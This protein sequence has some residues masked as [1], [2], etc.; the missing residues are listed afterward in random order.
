MAHNSK[1]H[2]AAIVGNVAKPDWG[3]HTERL[4]REWDYEL[5]DVQGVYPMTVEFDV[6]KNAPRWVCEAQGHAWQANVSIRID[7][8]GCPFC[9]KS[10]S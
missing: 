8:H 9:A 5:N 4:L 7:G 2:S 1:N 3:V 6:R 10:E